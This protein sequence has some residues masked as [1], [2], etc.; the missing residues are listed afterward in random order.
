MLTR[1]SSLLLVSTLIASSPVF[2][3]HLFS[4]GVKGGVPLTNDFSFNLTSEKNYVVGPMAE[5]NLPGGVSVEADA[6]YRPLTWAIPYE[7]RLRTTNYNSWEFPILGKYHLFHT[8]LVK[9]YVE[10]GPIFRH[11]SPG[12]PASSTGLALGGG[13]DF[14]VLFL[15]FEPEIRY[16]AGVR[17]LPVRLTRSNSLLPLLFDWARQA[18]RRRS[19]ASFRSDQVRLRGGLSRLLWRNAVGVIEFCA[20]RSGYWSF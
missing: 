5:L 6:L 15:R 4:F 8:P 12:S 3:Q 20:V 1:N 7:E 11:A 18:G 13:V 10:G 19:R 17:G 14:K 2:G 9:P 16:R